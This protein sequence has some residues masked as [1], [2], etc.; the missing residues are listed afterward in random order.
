MSTE[1][2]YLGKYE[3]REHLARGGQ[4]EVWKAFDTQLRRYVAIK[5]LHADLQSD[6]DFT[7]RFEREA[8]FIASLRHPNIVQIH[9]FQLVR[10]SDSGNTTA[11]MVMD[12]IEGPTLADY[13]RNT[14]R[15]GQFPA[16]ADIVYIFTAVSLAIDYAH[17][18]GMIHR[19]IKPANIILDQRFLRRNALG[20]PILTDFGIAKLQGTSADTTKVLGTPLYVSP[21][22]AQ[23]LA[24]D[25]RSDLYSL[26][27]ILYEI[28]TGV[29]PFRGDSVMSILMQHF[30]EPPTPPALLNPRIPPTLSDV[31]LKSITKDPYARFP[32]ASAMT[33]AV[34]QSLNVALPMELLK[35]FN[36]TPEINRA[37][38]H[39]SLQ[40]SESLGMTP[41]TL[42]PNLGAN[43]P[44]S[45][46]A[47]SSRLSPPAVLQSPL[48]QPPVLQP[49]RSQ[50]PVRQRK[51]YL[52]LLALLIVAVVGSG[53]LFAFF[54]L[55]R[56]TTPSL[57]NSVV[58]HV[59]FLSSSN[60]PQASLDKVEITLQPIPDAPAGKRYYAWLQINSED[61]LPIHWPL[62]T[63]NGRLSSSPYT[64]PLLLKNKPYL[65]LITVEKADTDPQ[66]ATF[67]PGGRLYY[68]TLPANIQQAA[69]FDI[70]PCPQNGTTGI[71]MS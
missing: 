30:Q 54:A 59:R 24:G 57:S 29:T 46:P 41:A 4:G 45:D 70:R 3:L 8:R 56:T 61:L 49:P 17:E 11:Y 39:N 22:Q 6:P 14:S 52:I 23:G 33:I 9:D 36:P 67:A 25:K 18:Q 12:Y 19:D 55:N 26:G 62:T 68:A 44:T 47:Q 42:S 31:I 50:P 35:K 15:S 65:F 43:T 71:C 37:N 10:T 69:T 66:V 16:A 60:A 48:S 28:T 13:I 7:S 5:Q 1:P 63:Q 58:G 40:P 51:T 2:R 20:T 21:E 32:T 53:L 64:N 38:S 34:A 27:I